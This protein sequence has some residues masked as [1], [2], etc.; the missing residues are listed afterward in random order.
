MVFGSPTIDNRCIRYRLYIDK[1]TDTDDRHMQYI[2]IH[3]LSRF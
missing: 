2:I 3:A 1:L